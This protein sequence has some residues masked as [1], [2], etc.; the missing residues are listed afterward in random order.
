MWRKEGICLLTLW[1]VH[2]LKPSLLCFPFGCRTLSFTSRVFPRWSL[3]KNNKQA[4]VDLCKSL[5]LLPCW[6]NNNNSSSNTSLSACF[7][8]RLDVCRLSLCRTFTHPH[9]WSSQDCS[10]D[11]PLCVSPP[12]CEW[13]AEGSLSLTDGIYNCSSS[14]VV[15]GS[16]CCICYVVCACLCCCLSL[17]LSSP[18]WARSLKI[19]CEFCH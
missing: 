17:R 19:H 6:S 13:R 14:S 9:T 12:G 10:I 1:I 7:H 16:M 2:R 8:P 11:V 5:L 3:R 15:A 4:G 18:N